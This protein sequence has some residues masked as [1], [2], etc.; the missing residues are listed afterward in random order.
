MSEH[1]QSAKGSLGGLWGLNQMKTLLGAGHTRSNQRSSVMRIF[2]V[3]AS[4][5]RSEALSLR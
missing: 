4:S 5:D 3:V 1:M 2:R